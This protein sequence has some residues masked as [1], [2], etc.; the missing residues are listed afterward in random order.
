MLMK[1]SD[2]YTA[3]RTACVWCVLCVHADA[4]HEP[5]AARVPLPL[6]SRRQVLPGPNQVGSTTLSWAATCISSQ[7]C[8]LQAPSCLFDV[9]GFTDCLMLLRVL[10]THPC[11]WYGAA[12]PD[13][14]TGSV[15]L[16]RKLHRDAWTGSFSVKVCY[17]RVR[18]RGMHTGMQNTC[19][20]H[21]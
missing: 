18:K 20:W 15:F 3:P 10:M 13:A 16:E 21:L 9:S 12:L 7:G 19:P 14:A 1:I 8:L 17:A 4:D 5:G 6:A 2:W 11:R